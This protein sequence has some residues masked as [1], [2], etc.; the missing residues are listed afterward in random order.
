MGARTGQ[1]R[2]LFGIER[3]GAERREADGAAKPDWD[4]AGQ[5]WGR[6]EALSGRELLL[7]RQ[8]DARLSHRITFYFPDVR[9]LAPFTHRLRRGERLFNI[10]SARNL[11]DEDAMLEVMAEEAVTPPRA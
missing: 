7:A 10:V 11:E 3:R 1:R 6:L 2:T 4:P 9:D 5:A 8:S